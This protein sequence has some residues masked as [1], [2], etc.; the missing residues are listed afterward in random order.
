MCSSYF[1]DNMH[2]NDWT[3]VR[4]I[5]LQGIATGNA[6]FQQEAP[7]WNEWDK[8]HLSCC[9]FVVRSSDRVSGWAAL[10]AISSRC[11]YAGV[12]EVSVYVDPDYQGKG[13]G[14]SLMKILIED[15][16]K[17]GIWTLQAGIFP[18]NQSSIALHKKWGFKE[19]GT[20]ERIGEMNGVWRDVILLER[21]SKAVGI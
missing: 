21:R 9:R 19:V 1:I 3:H 10:S 14:S 15:S 5:Y 16:E 6:T 20:R 17:N 2:T 4:N 12:A 11:V 13:L 8:S 7:S 18:E